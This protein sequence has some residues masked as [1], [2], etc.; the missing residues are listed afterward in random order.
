MLI[1]EVFTCDSS[2]YWI[3]DTYQSRF[4]Q[5]KEPQK[6]DKDVFRDYLSNNYTSKELYES[7]GKIHI[8]DSIFDKLGTVYKSFYDN[9]F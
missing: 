4:L 9:F 3:K 8:P 6:Y 7:P 5:G 2:R 1:D